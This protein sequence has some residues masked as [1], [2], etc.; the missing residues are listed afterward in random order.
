[1]LKSFSVWFLMQHFLKKKQTLLLVL[2]ICVYDVFY[3]QTNTLKKI[4]KPQTECGVF[5]LTLDQRTA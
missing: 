2:L 5:A 3:E 1:M 4:E